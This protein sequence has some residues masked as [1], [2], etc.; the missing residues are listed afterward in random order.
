MRRR[1]ME[2]Q[3]IYTIGH[4]THSIDYFMELLRAYSV[5]CV[6][7]VRSV[8]ASSRNP[9][10][11]QEPFSNFLRK[12]G[13]DYLHFPEGFGA[14]HSDPDLLDENGKVDFLKVQRSWNFRDGVEKLWLRAERGVTIALM[15]SESDPF[16]CHRFSMISIALVKDGFEVKHILKDKS[17]LSNRDLEKLL[18]KK[19]EKK[20]TQPDMFN[21]HITEADQLRQAYKMRNQDIA[22]SPSKPEAAEVDD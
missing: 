5:T 14:R 3:V 7:D 13:V 1:K 19:Y 9:Q 6:V 2:R 20:L 15:C 22:Y 16:E 18:F 11:N 8:P 10:Y 17:L 21:P 4:S 12:S